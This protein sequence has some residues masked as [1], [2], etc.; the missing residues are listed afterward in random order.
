MPEAKSLIYERI[1]CQQEGLGDVRCWTGVSGIG[2]SKELGATGSR[3][4]PRCP[5]PE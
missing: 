4:A 2:R 3:P 5:E 1:D